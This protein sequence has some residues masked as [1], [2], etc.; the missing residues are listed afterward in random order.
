M[1]LKMTRNMRRKKPSARRACCERLTERYM[2]SMVLWRWLEIRILQEMGWCS[3]QHDGVVR[4]ES[5]EDT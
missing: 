3:A 4:P 5:T 1:V 2:T